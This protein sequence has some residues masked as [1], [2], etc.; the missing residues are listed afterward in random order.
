MP[1]RAFF[2]RDEEADQTLDLKRKRPRRAFGA[3][4][5][6]FKPYTSP[7]IFRKLASLARIELERSENDLENS[8]HRGNRD[9]HISRNTD[10]LTPIFSA[11]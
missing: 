6:F 5:P 9:R 1:K 7:D 10:A 4:Q 2:G 3:D 8:A 11:N